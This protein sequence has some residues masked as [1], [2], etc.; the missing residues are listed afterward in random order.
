MNCY[1]MKYV[2][3]L[4]LLFL[5]SFC[6][7][8]SDIEKALSQLSYARFYADSLHDSRRALNSYNDLL[9]LLKGN[10]NDSLNLIAQT[11]RIALLKRIGERT[12]LLQ[13]LSNAIKLA[14]AHKSYEQLSYLLNIRGFLYIQLGFKRQ[15]LNI[16]D[17]A[18]ESAVNIQDRDNRNLYLGYNSAAFSYITNELEEKVFNLTRA[19]R[20]FMDISPTSPKYRSAQIS[21]NSY[22][23]SAFI[24][25]G[26][27]DSATHYLKL[28]TSFLDPQNVL[29]DDYYAILNFANL[30]YLREDYSN[31]KKWLLY[32]LEQAKSESNSYRQGIIYFNLYNVEFI[33]GE[34]GLAN[35]Y[36]RSYANLKERLD[37]TQ[38]ENINLVA[39]ELAKSREQT[40]EDNNQQQKT[41]ITILIIIT[42]LF[43]VAFAWFLIKNR[44]GVSAAVSESENLLRIKLIEEGLSFQNDT[45]VQRNSIFLKI[46]P[47]SNEPKDDTISMLLSNQQNKEVTVE[48]INELNHLVKTNN[49][50]FMVKFHEAFPTF[51][52]TINELACPPL[53]NSEIEIC[54]C[55]KLNFTT[56]EIALY[57]NY[58]LRS[59]E[60][61]KFRI[62]KKLML[63]LEVDFVVW[64]AGI[65]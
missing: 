28:S 6:F 36:L 65:K 37:E 30:Y 7:A 45:S 29:P 62:R 47:S 1:F 50:S 38:I 42:F 9:L 22:Y 10:K 57:R 16:L 14:K 21:G 3:T 52:K 54:A 31:A 12:E 17:D 49:P 64:I 58:T 20:Y 24:E 11:E 33:L 18:H 61:R 55:T 19:Y 4:I 2:F 51:A 8:L 34:S 5:S 13:S 40:I 41:I 39:S 43:C 48:Q 27:L 35:E 23:A 25:E 53:N 44:K 26:R 56:K 32:A 63:N 59:V 60:N 46:S 15:A